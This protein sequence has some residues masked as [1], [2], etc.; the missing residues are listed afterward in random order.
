VAQTGT[1]TFYVD[2]ANVAK[3]DMKVKVWHLIDL[4]A[5][6]PASAAPKTH[7]SSIGQ[8]EYDCARRQYR[9]GYSADY[10]GPMGSG[11]PIRSIIGSQSWAPIA[12]GSADELMWVFACSQS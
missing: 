7:Q 5:P 9:N 4:A 8:S 1:A 6:S 11:L 2:T 10:A 3:N 12:P